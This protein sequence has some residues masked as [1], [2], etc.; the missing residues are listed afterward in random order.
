MFQMVA[1][2][3]RA[4]VRCQRG[5]TEIKSHFLFDKRMLVSE[6]PSKPELLLGSNFF[7]QFARYAGVGLAIQRCCDLRRTN[8]Y[9]VLY[10]SGSC[11]AR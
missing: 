4:V 2:E 10:S 5:C 3:L 9:G 11:L 6:L 8:E 7:G 1:S